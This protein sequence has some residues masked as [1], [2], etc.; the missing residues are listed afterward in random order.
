MENFNFEDFMDYGCPVC[1]AESNEDCL[2]DCKGVP[3]PPQMW[4][5]VEEQMAYVT[6]KV[7]QKMMKEF[8]MKLFTEKLDDILKDLKDYKGFAS[9]MVNSKT[10]TTADEVLDFFTSPNKYKRQYVLWNE[11]G[12]PIDQSK[13]HGQCL[14]K[15]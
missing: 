11:L 8:K 7:S 1:G 9:A 3:V 15:R 13:R 2:D 10:L 14:W 4:G 5:F 12:K 6:H